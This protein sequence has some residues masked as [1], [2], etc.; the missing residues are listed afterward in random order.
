MPH[1]A[2]IS[3]SRKDRAFA[4]RL[5]QALGNYQ[6]PKDIPVPQRRL[7]VFRDED[8][9]TGAEYY[10]AVDEHLSGATKLIV[11]CSPAARASR[12]V[13]DEIRRFARTTG[14]Q[15]IIA[16]L[17]AGVP[18]NEAAPGQEDLKAFPEALCEVM[19][20]PL[21]ADYR[22]F[23]SKRSRV[24]RDAYEASWYTTLANI[25]GI[26]RAEIEQRDRK[27]RALQLKIRVGASAVAVVVLLSVSLVAL[28]MWL[29]AAQ[30]QSRTDAQQFLDD[31]RRIDQK[32]PGQQLEL[33]AL[34][35]ALSL[36]AHWT[37]DGYEAW[38]KA[39][40]R[41]PRIV[42]GIETDSP[43]LRMAFNADATRL[44]ALCGE[45]HIHV[46]SVPEL[47]EVQRF[48]ASQT[49]SELT[50]DTAG[51]RAMA[52]RPGDVA[53]EVF[54]IAS[55]KKTS[56]ESPDPLHAAAFDHA[57]DAI[58]A[59]TMGLWVADAVSAGGVRPRARFLP[60]TSAIALSPS[61]GTVL[62]LAGSKLQ[63]R[64]TANGALRW[65]LTLGSD[66]ADRALAFS[67][68]GRSVLVT[69]SR[70]L[71][72]V[73]ATTGLVTASRPAQPDAH[74]R[75]LLL[76]AQ[77]QAIGDLLFAVDGQAPLSRLPAV[78]PTGRYI[79][80]IDR[81]DERR[82]IVA[83]VLRSRMSP[84]DDDAD[85]Y[86]SLKEAHRGMAAAFPAD[87][88][89]L[90]VSSHT[91][92]L[93]PGRGALQLVSL[94]PE[95]WRPIVP[96][97]SFAGDV[98]V[99]PPDAR[100]VARPLGAEADRSFNA[101]GGALE[102]NG[103]GSF[104][105][106]NG[107]LTARIEGAHWVVTDR[108]DGRRIAIP[109]HNNSPIVFAPDE[110]RVL[111]FPAVYS[112]QDPASPRTVAGSGPWYQ[113]WSYPGSNLVI[114]LERSK[115]QIGAAKESVLFDWTT[116]TVSVGPGSFHSL[117]A[118]G[119]D[120]R[121]FATYQENRI[122]VWALGGDAPLLVGNAP[123]GHDA[124][125]HFSPDGELIAVA[126]CPAASL[127]LFDIRAAAAGRFDALV[128]VLSGRG[129]GAGDPRPYGD[130]FSI[131]LATGC[132]AG[133]TLDGRYVLSRAWYSGYPQPTAHPITW[134][135]VQQETCAKVRT[136]RTSEEWASPMAADVLKELQQ[137]CPTG[138]DSAES[139]VRANSR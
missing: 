4:I 39:T 43:L 56:F 131:P 73:D 119:L 114:G 138:V 29:E 81:R 49:A 63:A 64:D 51:R 42:A 9:F 113:A 122:A 5:Q 35:A 108:T 132:F 86:V 82:F 90:A 120:G 75:P 32:Y 134:D 107:R 130:S 72:I 95:R 68:D 7:S 46:F 18:N 133:F 67:G 117:Y 8:D 126:Y 129:S 137:I 2:F 16:L 53:A 128:R 79:A 54:D 66:N 48:D 24:D 74:G 37:R 112:L 22:G 3:Y 36:R 65:E 136:R 34:K 98:S 116:E 80:G 41:M 25:Y 31:A 20:M 110:R 57:G 97:R 71:T 88:H 100:V 106:A 10:R 13:D 91:A 76:S 109:H 1:D 6:P 59:S 44:V 84:T 99:L 14:P 135:G 101:E 52:Y 45:R 12:Y 17:V 11:L 69:G 47:R 60:A 121:R 28:Q 58:V 124:P 40:L 21:A 111:V 78:D 118:V 33:Q 83:D 127:P 125:P 89:L 50:V 96:M 85:F 115:Y 102:G 103:G 15:H 94:R 104:V 38:R 19:A 77:Q 23:D 27:R 55:G 26:S 30:G 87:G 62:A 92:G 61:G 123:S 139:G 105:S 70:E 93:V